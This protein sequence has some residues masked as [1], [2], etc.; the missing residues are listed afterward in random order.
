MMWFPDCVKGFNYRVLNFKVNRQKL[1]TVTLE[2]RWNYL[3]QNGNL[4]TKIIHFSLRGFD[5]T[6]REF[7]RKNS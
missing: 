6:L 2:T 4:I 7:L 1:L 3:Y 5:Y